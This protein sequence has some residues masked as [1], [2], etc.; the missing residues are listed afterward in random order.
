MALKGTLRDFGIA[1][2]LQLIGQQQKT[3]TLHLKAKEQEV[4][5]G[6]KDGNIVKA[7]SSTRNKK[8][9]I[10]NMLARA[11]LITDQQLQFA[12]ENQKRTLKRLGDVL[13]ATGVIT[14]DRFK[15][16]VQLQMTETLYKLFSWKAGTYEFEQV[17]VDYDHEAITPLRA[18]SVLMEGFRMVDEWPLIKKKITSYAMTFEKLKDLPL[19]SLQADGFDAAL[20]DAFAEKKTEGE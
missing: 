16:F 14:A 7:E 10:G 9:L 4:H 12:L 8:D 13:V 6:F 3:G 19:S 2:I 5:I 15:A 20:D 1:D 11:E 17:E 18:E